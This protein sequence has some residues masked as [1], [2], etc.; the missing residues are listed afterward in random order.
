[1]KVLPRSYAIHR[2]RPKD[3]PPANITDQWVRPI[4][5]KSEEQW[6]GNRTKDPCSQFRRLPAMVPLTGPRC[7]TA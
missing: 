3:G 7:K 4:Q 2:K 1:M 5:K 6:E